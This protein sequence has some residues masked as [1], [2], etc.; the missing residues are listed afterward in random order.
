MKRQLIRWSAAML[1]GWALCSSSAGQS[2]PPPTDA[3]VAATAVQL[4]PA[5][6]DQIIAPVALYADPLLGAVFAAATY[7]LEVVEA[8]RWLADPAHAALQGDEL[9][10]AL[11]G[12]S[13]DQSVKSLVSAPG[14]LRMLND[15]L[16]W[17]E[18]LG[19]AF[20]AQQADVMDSVQRLR[21]RAVAAGSLNST[22]QQT[23]STQ[24][25]DIGIEP[26]N[27]EVVYVP[28][29]VPADVYGPWPWPEY[30]P[31]YFG[32]PPG[33][34]LGGGL[35]AFGLGIDM[36]A[37]WGWYQWNWRGHG[38]N[39]YP[40][41]SPLVQPWQHDPSHRRG[42]PYRDGAL[43]AR[44]PRQEPESGREFRG[45]PAET[46]RAEAEHGLPAIP[47]GRPMAP[48]FESFGRGTQ[49]RGEAARGFSSRSAPAPRSAPAGGYHGGGHSEGRR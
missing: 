46:P 22:P 29:Y 18:Q 49:V 19:D 15:N 23:V 45:F 20:L 40:G 1:A 42:V 21:Q 8:A 34:V 33:I 7:P 6:L 39:V 27:P 38:F 16:Q 35:I 10:A 41:H 28:Y 14:V 32:V 26:T 48:A 2:A 3:P 25:Q 13:W 47:S 9:T 30:P 36:L 31:F 5:E 11:Q 17:T 4:S 44:Y 24:D 37:P 12:Q 43:A